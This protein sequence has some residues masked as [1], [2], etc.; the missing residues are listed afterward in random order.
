[1]ANDQNSVRQK[2]P[3]RTHELADVKPKKPYRS[4]TLLRWGTL[5]EMT[6]A[7]GSRGNKDGGRKPYR[8]TR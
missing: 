4:P 8:R 5:A 7:V 2:L 1:M 6:G 3:S